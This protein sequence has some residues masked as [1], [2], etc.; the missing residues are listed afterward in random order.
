M[1][2]SLVYMIIQYIAKQIN[3]RWS[4][5]SAILLVVIARID[6][7]IS[8]ICPGLVRFVLLSYVVGD[9][10]ASSLLSCNLPTL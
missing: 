9:E 3:Q 5:V 2:C 8:F 6:I 1:I 10:R 7:I 4:F